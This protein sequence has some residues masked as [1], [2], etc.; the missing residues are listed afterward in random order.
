MVGQKIEIQRKDL[1]L[2][3]VVLNEKCFVT[4][5]IYSVGTR[6]IETM[7]WKR[8]SRKLRFTCGSTNKI[9]NGSYLRIN[10]MHL[11]SE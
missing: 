4:F 2:G 7:L 5:L 6:I 9:Q 3:S 11:C 1:A 10:S 8:G